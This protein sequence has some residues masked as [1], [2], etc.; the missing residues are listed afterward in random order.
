MKLKSVRLIS[1]LMIL[2]MLMGVIGCTPNDPNSGNSGNDKYSN[3]LSKIVD[4]LPLDEN[5]KFDL[6]L[7]DNVTL[8][9]WSV[10][11]NPD[12]KTFEKLISEFN[13]EY[14]GMIEIKLTSVG[15]NDYYSALNTTYAHDYTNFPDVCI[16]HNEKNIEYALKKYFYPID[17][18]ITKTGVGIDFANAYDNIEKTTI[19]DGKHYGVPVDAHGYLIQI[20]QDII[21]KNGLGFDGNTRFIPES[22]E[23]HLTLL[24]GLR[25]KADEGQLY[26]R[27]INAGEDHSWYIWKDGEKE[28]EK[29]FPYFLH[30]QECDNL[31]AL[32]VNGGSL[33]DESGK[34]AFHK[35]SGFMKYVEDWVTRTNE[36][37]IGNAGEKEAAF[38]E[39]RIVMFS[40]GPWYVAG[41]YDGWWNNAE[42]ATAGNG[43]SAAD[44]K[45]PIY[46]HPYAVA[47]PNF[48][49]AEGAP[50]STASKWYGNGHV[51]AL[52]NKITSMQ[53][54]AAALIFAEWLTQA[55]NE[56]GE[57][58]LANWCKAGHL[59]A[60]KN[61]YESD[62]Y[63][64]VASKSITLQ[65]MG[66]PANILALEST[67]YASTLISGLNQAVGGVTAELLS[68][69]CTLEE[70]RKLIEEHAASTQDALILLNMG[71]GK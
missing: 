25:K 13:K 23:E 33:L 51:V 61:V 66:D 5:G 39:G 31:T 62:S 8:N 4:D 69:G 7:L 53:K 20:R 32:Y 64:A 24:E 48:M 38:G 35:N 67:Q 43:V 15:H 47:R 65:A 34:V 6:M 60:W 9:L 71:I 21:K 12:L 44:A 3:D 58:N 37:L 41:T 52:T 10:I 18:L 55:Q 63:K 1:I 68:D 29:F 16:M 26:V 57:Y 40:E 2:T 54:A 17:E 49:A 36:G 46:S 28:T 70:A 30:S 14:M 56:D 27:N 50:E 45:D 59:P 42:L 22:Y 11:G 19:H